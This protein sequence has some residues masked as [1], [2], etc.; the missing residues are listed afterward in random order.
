MATPKTTKSTLDTQVI[1]ER[2]HELYLLRGCEHG[3]DLDDWLT[4]ESEVAAKKPVKARVVS[5]KRTLK[6]QTAA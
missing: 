1:A 5:P 2:A 6:H 3:H 4:A